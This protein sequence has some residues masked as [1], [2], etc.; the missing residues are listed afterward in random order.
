M[1]RASLP[2]GEKLRRL[3]A[4]GVPGPEDADFEDEFGGME[5]TPDACSGTWTLAVLSSLKE[6]GRRLGAGWIRRLLRTALPLGRS[7]TIMFNDELL[8][9]AKARVEI[10]NEWQLGPGLNLGALILSDDEEVEVREHSNPYPHLEIPELGI[11]TGR[12][13][14]YKD[15]ISGGKSEDTE[16]SNGFFVNVRG[17]V[18][19][20]EDPYFGLENLSHSVWSRFRATVR[21]DGLD[22][23]LAVNR[24]AILDSRQLRLM[25]SLLMKLFNRARTKYEIDLSTPWFDIN[26]V[27]TK[28][29]G[30]LPFQPFRR[31]LQDS[32]ARG[33][34]QHDFIVVP[35][36][37]DSTLL[38]PTSVEISQRILAT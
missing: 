15:R 24:E 19:K 28:S 35:D 2:D 17:R 29:Y 36:G 13:R 27:L 6:P 31:V 37:K 7:I 23:Q 3:I 18:I 32:A 10:D 30:S 12:V 25:R 34:I 22:E 16:A 14:L 33:G 20:P 11:V 26:E 5:P 38:L 8:S 4:E 1:I 9:S 21:A